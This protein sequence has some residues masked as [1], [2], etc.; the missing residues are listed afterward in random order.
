MGQILVI[1]PQASNGL[2]RGN[3]SLS[4]VPRQPDGP[5]LGPSSGKSGIYGSLRKVLNLLRLKTKETVE[6]TS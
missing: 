4:L 1:E 3:P 2:Q 5:T 6:H